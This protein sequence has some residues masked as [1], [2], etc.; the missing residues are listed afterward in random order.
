MDLLAYVYEVFDTTPALNTQSRI[1]LGTS[2][3]ITIQREL[4][5]RYGS[6]MRVVSSAPAGSKKP[7]L[8][9]NVDGKRVQF[10]IK[11]RNSSSSHITMFD[12]SI[13]RDEPNALLD[14]LAYVISSGK[15][16]SFEQ[17]IDRYRQSNQAVGFPGDERTPKSGKLPP[18]LRT[19]EGKYLE[20]VFLHI[21]NHFQ[22]SGDN[23]FAVFNRDKRDVEIYYTGIGPNVL[24][25]PEFPMLSKLI[26]DTYGG[27]YEG[28][29]RVALKVKLASHGEMFHPLTLKS[30]LSGR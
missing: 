1:Q 9:V 16:R 20:P 26:V 14:E 24:R 23:Y 6:R 22:E 29:M 10:E 21:M 11:G 15:L 13:R 7:D 8:I 25:A 19:I 18:E 30:P 4:K 17:L 28:A 2:A 5:R 27:A 3:Q 12:T